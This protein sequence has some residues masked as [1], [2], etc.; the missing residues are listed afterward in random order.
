MP[1]IRT[2]AAR[3]QQ[4]RKAKDYPRVTGGKLNKQ[5]LKA[6]RQAKLALE[7]KYG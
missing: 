5:A 1:K 4:R 7:R 3:D 2:A 6:S